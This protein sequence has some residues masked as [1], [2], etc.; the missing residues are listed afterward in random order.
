MFG[1]HKG[2]ARHALVVTSNCMH[3]KKKTSP[4]ILAISISK[5]LTWNYFTICVVVTSDMMNLSL[6]F[7]RDSVNDGRVTGRPNL[8]NIHS[9]KI[10]MCT[11]HIIYCLRHAFL[12]YWPCDSL[13]CSVL[14]YSAF[15]VSRITINKLYTLSRYYNNK[16]VMANYDWHIS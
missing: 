3:A 6:E 16:V 1:M 15:C 12:L 11:G 13:L 7:Q 4:L 10:V 14:Q 2:T 8:Y 5:Q 9:Y